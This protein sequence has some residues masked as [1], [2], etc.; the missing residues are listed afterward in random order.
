VD[1]RTAL[2]R[3]LRH[4][5]SEGHTPRTIRAYGQFV[6]QFADFLHSQGHNG[7]IEDLPADDL[8]GCLEDCRDNGTPQPDP[9]KP[10]KPNAPKSVRTKTVHANLSTAI[11]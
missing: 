9:K 7:Q 6:G 4:H 5:R 2:E 11:G 1:V 3:Y 8:R 10:R